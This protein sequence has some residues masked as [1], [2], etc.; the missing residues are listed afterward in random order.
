MTSSGISELSGNRLHLRFNFSAEAAEVAI[1]WGHFSLSVHLNERCWGA[2]DSST[3]GECLSL[4]LAIFRVENLLLW[5]LEGRA[6]KKVGLRLF[7]NGSNHRVGQQ[8]LV[9]AFWPL[10]FPQLQP[11]GSG[12]PFYWIPSLLSLL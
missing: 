5:Q 9:R 11:E 10:S 8:N 12:S 7:L 3:V 2:G 6:M 4:Q 1:M